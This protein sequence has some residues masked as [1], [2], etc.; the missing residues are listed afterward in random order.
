MNILTLRDILNSL[1]AYGHAG[2]EVT[3]S[4]L[5]DVTDKTYSGP[6]DSISAC[7]TEGV[8]LLSNLEP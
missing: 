1:I 3:I 6:I 5:D 8:K 7:I 2:S 4:I